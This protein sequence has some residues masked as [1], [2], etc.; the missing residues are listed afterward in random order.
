M[1]AFLILFLVYITFH[2]A[3]SG[4]VSEPLGNSSTSRPPK[5]EGKVKDEMLRV[6]MNLLGKLMG[7]ETVVCTSMPNGERISLEGTTWGKSIQ[8]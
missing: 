6:M 8:D 4:N 2:A 3:W 5:L 7:G 1:K